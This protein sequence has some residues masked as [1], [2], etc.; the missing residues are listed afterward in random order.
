MLH[1]LYANAQLG[2]S[3]V[4][5]PSAGGLTVSYVF[6]DGFVVIRAYKHYV[7]LIQVRIIRSDRLETS[8]DMQLLLLLI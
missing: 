1:A 8:L 2:W 5:Q 6:V 7:G 4:T 3:N